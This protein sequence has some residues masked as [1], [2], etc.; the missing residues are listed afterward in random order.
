MAQKDELIKV[1]THTAFHV[2]KGAVLKVM[3]TKWTAG[4]KQKGNKGTLT[5][6]AERRP[7]E[8][9]QKRIQELVNR[10]IQ[11]KSEI[12]IHH[13]DRKEAEKKWGDD[14]YDLFPLPESVTDL[15]VLEI[16][17]WNLNCCGGRHLNH[18]GELNS[19]LLN[20]FK[21]REN[22]CLLEISFIVT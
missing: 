8:D 20:K 5:V 2:V 21:F 4:V 15:L 13:I 22:K 1:M 19:V 17:D 6:K 12:L 14:I 10:K 18:T 9:E 16:P 11:E 3:G 7:T